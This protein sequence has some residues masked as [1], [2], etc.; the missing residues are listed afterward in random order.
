MQISDF[1]DLKSIDEKVVVVI[2]P[3][4]GQRLDPEDLDSVYGM[5]GSTLKHNFNGNQAWLITSNRESLRKV[6]LKPAEKHTLFNGAL[7]CILLKYDLYEGSRK[8]GLH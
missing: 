6:G 2:N 5:I 1:K 7:E 3:P 4:Y 8:T